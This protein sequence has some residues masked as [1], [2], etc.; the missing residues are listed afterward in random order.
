MWA[1]FSSI[2]FSFHLSIKQSL[3]LPRLLCFIPCC[4]SVI[5]QSPICILSQLFSEFK[6]FTEQSANGKSW[7]AGAVQPQ[8]VLEKDLAANPWDHICSVTRVFAQ[9]AFFWQTDCR[10]NSTASTFALSAKSCEVFLGR[11]EQCSRNNLGLTKELPRFQP[12]EIHVLC[13][14]N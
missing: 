11:M 2:F 13:P 1:C 6:R 5:R 4:S 9:R 12:L 8:G 3:P 14:E 7:L 10:K